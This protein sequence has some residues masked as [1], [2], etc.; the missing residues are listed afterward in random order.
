MPP[1]HRQWVNA[2]KEVHCPLPAGA[3]EVSR[4]SPNA[5]GPQVVRSTAHCPRAVRQCT[6][7]IPLPTS[8]QGSAAVHR[9]SSNTLHTA[10]F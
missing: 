1:A 8:P 10:R 6:G 9:R 2:Q 7:E 4:R 5:H 3:A